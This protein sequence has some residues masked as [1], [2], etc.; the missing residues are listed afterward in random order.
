MVC[1]VFCKNCQKV[2]DEFE[3][4]CFW[5][6]Q[7]NVQLN[8]FNDNYTIEDKEKYLFSKDQKQFNFMKEI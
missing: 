4:E 1:Y 7:K 6:K 2:V 3:S 8:S 5:C